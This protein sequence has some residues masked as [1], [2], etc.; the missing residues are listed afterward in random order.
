MKQFSE[1][2]GKEMHQQLETLQMQTDS[3]LKFSEKAI[4]ILIAI[5][6]Q[7]KTFFRKYKF[8]DKAEEIYFFKEIKPQFSSRL[9]YYNEIYNIESCRPFGTCKEIREHYSAELAKLNVFFNHNRAFY[10]YYMKG[11][12]FL[13]EQ[14]FLRGKHDVRLALDSFFFQSDHQFS[15]SHDYKVATILANDLIRIHLEKEL[16]LLD[17]QTGAS[18]L[19]PSGAGKLKWTGSKVGIIE[20]V[21]ALHTE[22][23]FNY[24]SCDLR[25]IASFFGKAFEVDL[26][27]FHRTFSEI[28]GRKSERTKFLNSLQENLVRR[29]EEHDAK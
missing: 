25:E 22:G 11:N 21:Y 23:V 17:E 9:V 2:L 16:L 18:N 12:T 8:Q 29:M 28:I 20:L 7:L 14:Y 19:I 15:T 13:D 26:G 24:G 10:S 5:L 1:Y 4:C 3:T 6:Q 27:Q